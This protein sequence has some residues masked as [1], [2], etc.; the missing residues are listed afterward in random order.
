[1]CADDLHGFDESGHVLLG[2]R[3]LVEDR[4][5]CAY[6]W[7][8]CDLLLPVHFRTDIDGNCIHHRCREG[9]ERQ[10][11]ALAFNIPARGISS[12]VHN[13]ESVLRLSLQ[14]QLFH[15]CAYLVTRVNNGHTA[16]VHECWTSN[17][18]DGWGMAV[19]DQPLFAVAVPLCFRG[20]L[21]VVQSLRAW[22][23]PQFSNL[24]LL[25]PLLPAIVRRHWCSR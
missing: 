22:W 6:C 15:T 7:H 20:V 5:L 1:M 12:G 25:H 3:W 9:Q 14:L 4:R 23:H 13:H 21:V 8:N 10:W 24:S 16:D 19:F 17:R 2:D 18:S 11:C